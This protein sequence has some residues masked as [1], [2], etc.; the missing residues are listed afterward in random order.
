MPQFADGAF[1]GVL[2]KGTL[3]AIVCGQ[4]PVANAAA[5]LAECCRRDF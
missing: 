5:A 1:A 2:D 3:D 4:S